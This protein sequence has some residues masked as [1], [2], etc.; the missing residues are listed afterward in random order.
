[1]P[2]APEQSSL[3]VRELAVGSRGRDQCIRT[4]FRAL[5]DYFFGGVD[6]EIRKRHPKPGVIESLAIHGRPSRTNPNHTTCRVI[7]DSPEL[8]RSEF[9]PNEPCQREAVG[10][11][12]VDELRRR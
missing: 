7:G 9:F 10:A 6:V 8:A 4:G 5:E 1:M 3:R 11:L 2:G 12:A